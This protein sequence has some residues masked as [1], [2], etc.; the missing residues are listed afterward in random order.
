M[1]RVIYSILIAVIVLCCLYI[2]SV[3]SGDQIEHE[4]LSSRVHDLHVDI[5]K[6]QPRLSSR[7]AWNIARRII[8]ESDANNIDPYIPASIIMRESSFNHGVRGK[9]GEVGLM[10]I[11]PSSAPLRHARSI[12][13]Q[14]SAEDVECNIQIGIAWLA[15]CRVNCDT[16]DPWIW[17]AAYGMKACPSDSKARRHVSSI[18]ARRYLCDIADCDSIWPLDDSSIS[19]AH[20][21]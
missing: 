21:G 7:A 6:L 11:M 14:C 15:Q 17:I 13:I 4:D 8:L 10:Q 2:T 20:G 3:A 9:R 19:F 1:K 16:D 18:R 12:G 5:Q